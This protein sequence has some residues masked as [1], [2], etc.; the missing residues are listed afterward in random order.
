MLK[1]F[2]DKFYQNN[3]KEKD[4]VENK[5]I[6]RQLSSKIKDN[7][8][9][10]EKSTNESNRI[11]NINNNTSQEKE[12]QE[13]EIFE[14]SK[15]NKFETIENYITTPKD[16]TLLPYLTDVTL[17]LNNFN[18]EN[19][20]QPNNTNKQ[21][22]YNSKSV[23]NSVTE[24][25]S[26]VN[27]MKKYSN[28]DS[29]I[30]TNNSHNSTLNYNSSIN[31][32][33]NKLANN[34]NF[35]AISI[36]SETITNN[37]N[38]FNN[39]NNLRT[40]YNTSNYSNIPEES[41]NNSE[42]NS[43]KN[44]IN[45]PEIDCNLSV[46]T[47]ENNENNIDCINYSKD[48]FCQCKKTN[49]HGMMRVNK[50]RTLMSQLFRLNSNKDFFNRK[51]ELQSGHLK[52]DNNV[53]NNFNIEDNNDD[54]LILDKIKYNSY[55]FS[56][57]KNNMK[58]IEDGIN[59]IGI[60]AFN[61]Y[62]SKSASFSN[63][64][65]IYNYNSENANKNTNIKKD[66]SN[67]TNNS[68]NKNNKSN[69]NSIN[70]KYKSFNSDEIISFKF[71][72]INDYKNRIKRYYKNLLL[73]SP[74]DSNNESINK[75][76]ID[77]NKNNKAIISNI[78]KRNTKKAISQTDFRFCKIN[79]TDNNDNSN[80][81]ESILCPICCKFTSNPQ[82]QKISIQDL[83]NI[84]INPNELSLLDNTILKSLKVNKINNSNNSI[85]ETSNITRNDINS[86]NNNKKTSTQIRMDYISKL[87]NNKI[88][89]PSSEQKK[90]DFNQII[91]FDWDDTLFCSS[92]FA[93]NGVFLEDIDL[94]DSEAEALAKL[95][96]SALHVLSL[97]LKSNSDVYIITNSDKGWVQYSS[98]R[99][100]PSIYKLL[101]KVIVI[102]CR[103]KYENIFPGDSRKWKIEAFLELAKK[104]NTSLSTNLISVGDS[105]LDLEAT[106]LLAKK[107][108]ECFL[109]LIKF[110]ESPSVKELTR[111]LTL[112]ANQFDL[113]F[114]SVKNMTIRVEKKKDNKE[115]KSSKRNSIIN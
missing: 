34:M 43:Y 86:I 33:L 108:N 13:F 11:I 98:E 78:C 39:N 66:Y 40:K 94:S 100:L 99:F 115:N 113:I 29:N 104:Y 107:F 44:F 69:Y 64:T 101:D 16:I 27:Q 62:I 42:N 17:P 37:M 1:Y 3:M 22:D 65:D 106:T 32:T 6:E 48:H 91:I 105:L 54:N 88:L 14:L 21:I 67:K 9:T 45:E 110:K 82:N 50:K 47:K 63:I 7:E 68:I 19:D 28:K 73:I 4:N 87:I 2:Y 51:N 74:T 49:N 23:K 95:E 102:S 84:A 41:F 18:D 8:E 56:Y 52:Q 38:N 93:P 90:N 109:K 75:E 114:K 80:I 85:E 20:T 77:N 112:I 103:D 96:F 71:N 15:R 35:E 31:N 10:K 5:E 79:N 89:L 97:A 46:I 111:Q 83:N 24:L 59:N 72:K 70:D 12:K 30:N 81:T 53:D 26:K 36:S 61:K 25:L 55:D 60:T 92:Y 58:M 57:S 76:N